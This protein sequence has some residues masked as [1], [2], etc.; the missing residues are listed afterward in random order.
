MPD[1]IQ[2]NSL[3]L[4]HFTTLCPVEVGLCL[5]PLSLVP[6]LVLQYMVL[7]VSSQ[8]EFQL[9]KVISCLHGAQSEFSE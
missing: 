3:A 4:H 5:F 9:A 7:R 6:L 1:A 8:S 2:M